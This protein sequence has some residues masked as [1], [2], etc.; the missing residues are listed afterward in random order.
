MQ[1][2]CIN[3]C[4]Y[5]LNEDEMF[6]ITSISKSLNFFIHLDETFEDEELNLSNSSLGVPLNLSTSSEESFSQPLPR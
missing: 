2:P 1:E 4:H 5:M 6:E 3:Y